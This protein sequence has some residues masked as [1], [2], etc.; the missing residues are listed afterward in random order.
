[1]ATPQR[2]NGVGSILSKDLQG[3]TSATI[4]ASHIPTHVRLNSDNEQLEH[5]DQEDIDECSKSSA[6]LY[7]DQERPAKDQTF[8]WLLTTPE[9]NGLGFWSW[10]T[11][12]RTTVEQQRQ[13]EAS[14]ERIGSALHQKLL[15]QRMGSNST[16]RTKLYKA[17]RA[18][19]TLTP[20]MVRALDM[21]PQDW[22][23]L[24]ALTFV[25]MGVRLFGISWPDEVVLDEAHV[26]KAVNAYL[27]NE[28]VVD[29][30]PPLGKLLLSGICALSNYNGSFAFGNIGD[31]YPGWVPYVSM[32][33]ANAFLGAL[34][35][36]MAYVTLK[37]SGHG[38]IASS[39]AAVLVT[40][41]NALT[42]NN[43]LAVLDA[44][45]MFFTAAAIMS[46]N[47]FVKQTAWSFTGKRWMWLFL[48][49]VAMSG[50]MSVK[51]AGISGAATIS[52]LS[53]EH[54]WSL[55][56]ETP[57]RRLWI[58]QLAARTGCLLALPLVIYLS[59][60]KVHFSYQ[61][62]A[63]DYERSI[64][65]EVDF[66]K[67]Q[68]SLRHSFK[69]KSNQSSNAETVWRDVVYGSVVQL[70]SEYNQG[71]YLHSF[72]KA[73]P[74]GSHQQQV[75]GYEYPDLNT[76]WIVVRA[77]QD[78]LNDGSEEIPARLTYLRNGDFLRLR[79]V[80]TR[81]CLHSHNVRAQRDPKNE[82]LHEVSAYGGANTD[83]DSND[84]WAI[85]VVDT[86]S[87]AQRPVAL[88]DK[89]HVI[90][91]LETTFRLKHVALGCYLFVDDTNLPRP[92]GEGRKD[93]ICRKA[94]SITPKSVWRIVSNEHDHLPLDTPLASYP[95]PTFLQ[96]VFEMH[97]LMWSHEGQYRSK[98][99]QTASRPWQ[100]P[101][102]R[103]AI[104]AWTRYKR[105]VTIVPNPIVWWTSAGGLVIFICAKVLFKLRE[106]RGY[107]ET[108]RVR[109]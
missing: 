92:W 66:Y 105:Q 79:H 72:Y 57:G 17:D 25:A 67:L 63:P 94:V 82:K 15:L 44:P 29:P 55:T 93:I 97:R 5:L 91:A 12:S 69:P 32:R 87:V 23:I 41:E 68:Q 26:G 74:G 43:R 70:R 30:H 31:P 90:R 54:L 100:W 98:Y 40:F 14:D 86:T 104:P 22:V 20:E 9:K 56:Q 89:Q 76:Q 103:S 96:K 62:Q 60:F 95:E 8:R 51:L 46:W 80:P 10:M 38:A 65:A 13:L 85:E 35:A 4:S 42:A 49:G 37:A 71:V 39:I 50:A 102:A 77:V 78:E 61:M 64:Q 47:L 53:L 81:R 16:N 75:S 73:I 99:H 27:K 58:K 19:Q 84:W 11:S 101:L 59:L 18:Y 1:M 83:G 24:S 45:L 7:N 107:F 2:P 6:T 28:F 48:T 109:G 33:T 52:V 3:T 108:G 106:K 21:T 36:P 34:C 88:T